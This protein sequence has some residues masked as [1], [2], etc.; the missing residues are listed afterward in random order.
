M[1]IVF[2]EI[3][4][5]FNFKMVIM[6]M[7]IS[8]IM[9]YLFISN[10]S[11]YS[12]GGEEYYKTNVQMVKDYGNSMDREEF[13]NFK[14]VYNNRIEDANRYLQSKPELV[15]AGIG[16]Y[17]KFNDMSTIITDDKLMKLRAKVFDDNADTFFELETRN[18]IIIDYERIEGSVG[19]NDAKLNKIQLERYSEV[20][21]NESITSIL[22]YYVFENYSRSIKSAFIL[23]VFSIIFMISPIFIKD[24]T[25]KINH[26]QY[27]S[28]T[29]RKTFK[30]KVYASLIS[31]FIIIS[32]N[33]ICFFIFYSRYKAGIFL[34]SSINSIFNLWYLSWFNISFI[35]YIALTV[36]AIYVL[37]FVITLIVTFI[38]RIA[39][40]YMTL[41]GVLVPI[42]F[43]GI[44][45]SNNFLLNRL[46]VVSVPKYFLL[47]AYSILVL[48][49]LMLIVIRWKKEKMVDI[50]D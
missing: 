43:I 48:I 27:T 49:G 23:I 7:F 16:T 14:Q 20:V 32:I 26:L 37:G 17:E 45:I 35:Q 12:L 42:T 46:T 10:N 15:S 22:P 33:F 34:S 9:Y 24:S 30:T 31:S 25:N 4:K 11:I 28:K 3:K 13:L 18:S 5:I 44:F 39:P 50:I 38:S 2:N 6:I 1:R 19:R 41:I 21:E 8:L 36:L 47:I 29:G 40:N